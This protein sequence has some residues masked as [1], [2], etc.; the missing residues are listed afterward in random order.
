MST[1][2]RIISAASRPRGNSI[3][4]VPGDAETHRGIDHADHAVGLRKVPP[5]F[6]AARVDMLREQTVAVAA[7]EYAL[8]QRAGLV[9]PS[10]RGQRVDIPEGADHEGVL[11][12]AEVIRRAVAEQ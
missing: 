4:L 11:R 9:L 8:E 3:G 1:P 2:K 6:A 7:A 10:Q 5:Q 12:D